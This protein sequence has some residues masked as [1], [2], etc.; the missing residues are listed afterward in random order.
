MPA[1]DL[2]AA[3]QQPL[4][5]HSSRDSDVM[6]SVR[7][8]ASPLFHSTHRKVPRD[9]HSAA[10]IDFPSPKLT[11]VENLIENISP[12]AINR[13]FIISII[14]AS[15]RPS[16]VTTKV[17]FCPLAGAKPLADQNSKP[18]AKGKPLVSRMDLWLAGR[19]FG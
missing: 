16:S 10:S 18:L 13:C 17:D 5:A 2:M 15:L 1:H 12:A 8:L 19:T 3:S 11:A 7:S 9:S 14:C 4:A 6:T